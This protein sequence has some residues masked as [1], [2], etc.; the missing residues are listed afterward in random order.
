MRLLGA[1]ILWLE[2]AIIGAEGD[3][4]DGPADAADAADADARATT[5]SR[6]ES[7][8]PATSTERCGADATE[9]AIAARRE[10]AP[11]RD[12]RRSGD[13]GFGEAVSV[14]VRVRRKWN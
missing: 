5:A 11:G 4:K 6:K 14:V 3:A 2:R 13:A 9:R 8:T 7:T 1:A 10:L 12:G